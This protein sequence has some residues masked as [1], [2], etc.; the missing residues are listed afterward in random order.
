MKGA[1]F[2]GYTGLIFTIMHYLSLRECTITYIIDQSDEN[3]K[4]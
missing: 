2:T 1:T 3:D 4:F